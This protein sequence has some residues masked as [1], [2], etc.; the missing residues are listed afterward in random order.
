MSRPRFSTSAVVPAA[1][2]KVW[3]ALVA[4]LKYVDA[5]ARDQ[6]RRSAGRQRL[7]VPL[8]DT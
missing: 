2:E 1:P 8:P 5:Q 3:P 4:S 6:I 7:S